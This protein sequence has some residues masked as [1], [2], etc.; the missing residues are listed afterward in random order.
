MEQ[1]VPW[2]PYRWASVITVV[3][4]SVTKWEFDQFSGVVSLCHIAVNNNV[5]ASTL[6]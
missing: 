4:K 6:T 2:V 3:N 1:V 5:S